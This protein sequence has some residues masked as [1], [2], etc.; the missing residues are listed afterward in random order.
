VLRVALAARAS[1]GARVCC[2]IAVSAAAGL[3]CFVLRPVAELEVAVVRESCF[4]WRAFGE[5][6]SE[7][8]HLSHPGHSCA[9][10]SAAIIAAMPVNPAITLSRVLVIASS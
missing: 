7:Q 1:S 2:G 9:E 5:A 4:A 6:L 8:A 3:A 10:A